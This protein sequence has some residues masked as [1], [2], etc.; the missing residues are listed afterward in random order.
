MYALVFLAVALVVLG[1]LTLLLTRGKG[2]RGRQFSIGVSENEDVPKGE[3]VW[4]EEDQ[5]GGGTGVTQTF[6][7]TPEEKTEEMIDRETTQFGDDLT[8]PRNPGHAAWERRQQERMQE[9]QA[10]QHGAAEPDPPTPS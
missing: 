2:N 1:G 7:P 8:D 3:D 5:L 6:V 9:G 10:S 4:E